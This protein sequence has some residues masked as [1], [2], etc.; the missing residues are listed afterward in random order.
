MLKKIGLLAGLAVGAIVLTLLL[1][2]NTLK[3]DLNA[4][5][6]ETGGII[7]QK[8]ISEGEEKEVLTIYYK[9]E[10]LGIVHDIDEY[11][12]FLKRIYEEKYAED[13]PNTEVGLGEDVHVSKTVSQLEA[14][15][16]DEEIFAYLEENNFFSIMGY[17]IE[18]S[19]GSIAYV[20]NSEDFVRAVKILY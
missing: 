1:P 3:Y 19:N 16:K 5:N 13:F 15:D 11:E 10:L 8:Y 20:K 6:L 18:F 14:E 7:P 9:D 2:G 4:Q 17:K 12:Q